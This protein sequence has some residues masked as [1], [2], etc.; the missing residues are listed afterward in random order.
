MRIAPGRG[1]AA[2]QGEARNGFGDRAMIFMKS[3]LLPRAVIYTGKIHSHRPPRN[4]GNE[5]LSL[6]GVGYRALNHGFA[7]T[8]RKINIAGK[9]LHSC[10]RENDHGRTGPELRRALG[11]HAVSKLR[12]VDARPTQETTWLPISDAKQVKE[13]ART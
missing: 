13:F 5:E 4:V 10:Y 7:D 1:G 9:A 11:P 8:L 2:H 12:L 3:Q 6:D